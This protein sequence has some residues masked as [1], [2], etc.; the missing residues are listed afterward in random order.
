MFIVKDCRW[1]GNIVLGDLVL[2]PS[3]EVHSLAKYSCEY[4]FELH[5]ND[6][7]RCQVDG[8]W[9]NVQPVCEGNGIVLYIVLHVYCYVV[10]LMSV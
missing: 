7:R 10:I 1:P 2:L 5:G 4:G 8:Q 6:T 3:S 9:S